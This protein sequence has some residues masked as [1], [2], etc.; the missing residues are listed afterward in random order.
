MPNTYLMQL[1]QKA[2]ADVSASD[3]ARLMLDGLPPVMW[4]IRRNMRQHRTCGL[5]VPQFRA[6]AVLNAQPTASLSAVAEYLGTSQP[7]TSRL[8]TGMVARGLVERHECATDRRQL[9]LRLTPQGNALLATAREATLRRLA[10]EVKSLSESDQKM[11]AGAMAILREMFGRP[12]GTQPP[13]SPA[14]TR[15]TPAMA[16]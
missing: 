16:S 3:C 1:L 12:E 15:Q 2:S 10:D 14:P 4:F 13:N 11:I 6:L 9:S 5:S 7:S 8:I